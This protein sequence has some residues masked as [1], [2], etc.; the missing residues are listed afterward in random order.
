[1]TLDSQ[2]TPAAIVDVRKM[3]KN[4]AAMQERMNALGVKFRP[5][6]KT[7]KCVDV[8]QAQ[9]AAGAR[10]ITVSTL[11]E[12]ESFFAAGIVDI[13]YA[14][15]IVPSKLP[16]VMALRKRGCDLKI[17]VDN[18]SAA[19]GI[20]EFCK[21]AGES[22]EVWIEVDTDGHRSGLKPEEDALLEIGRILHAGAI[23][24]GGVLTHAGSS[25][26]LNTPEA[27]A[28]L[29]EQER[30]GC[31]R[32]AQRLRAAGIPCESVSVGS[33]PTALAARSLEG[34]T[35]VRAGVYAFFDLVMHN[36]G[37]CAIDDIALSVL[38]TVIGHQEDKSW[39]IVDAGWMAMS[40]DR[41]TSKQSRDFGYGLPCALDGTPLDGYLMIGANQEHGILAPADA[42]HAPDH[43][44]LKARFPIGSRLR[45]LP[46]H[47]CA[48]GAQFPE[49][50]ALQATG[51]LAVWSRLH[52]W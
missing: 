19:L 41:G 28:A 35:E 3:K 22:L 12:A 5:H 6:V 7:S 37:V 9:I 40:R 24:V 23:K 17:V 26:E 11:K 30:A 45:I 36:V 20:V 25:Y 43:G 32:A 27:L 29:A 2:E 42:G 44:D 50:H 51:E 16:R 38:T 10:G 15:S 48:T 52:G 13:L 4:I 33:T 8:A 46:N 34:V 21:T 39:V 31:V 14:V 47:A 49:Y 18:A 1:M